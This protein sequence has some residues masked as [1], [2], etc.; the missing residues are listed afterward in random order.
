MQLRGADISHHNGENAVNNIILEYGNQIQFFIVKCTEGKTY[1][2]PKWDVN[3]ADVIS[4][5]RLLGL[6]H[7]ARPENN[8]S[9]AEA[10]HF[11]KYFNMY[12]GRAIPCLDWEDVALKHNPIWAL[13]WCET[14]ESITG[15]KPV[16]YVQQSEVKNMKCVQEGGYGLWVARW[17][18]NTGDISPWPFYAMW[19]YTNS[20]FD[21]NYFNGS[22]EQ[23]MAYCEPNRVITK[24][25]MEAEVTVKTGD[26]K[27]WHGKTTLSLAQDSAEA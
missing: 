27:T 18:K 15:V 13:E 6:Y 2:D 9:V 3:A 11:C 16:I 26:G 12:L 23:F 21:M 5:G 24:E 4:S 7:Y 22:R 8:T 17:G 14:V 25:T 1:V 20:P 19:Q 10:K